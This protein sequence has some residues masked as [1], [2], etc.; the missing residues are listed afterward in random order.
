M[1]KIKDKIGGGMDKIKDKMGGKG[2]FEIKCQ[3]EKINFSSN[4]E[5]K[6]ASKVCDVKPENMK[7]KKNE[8]T[9]DENEKKRD[10]IRRRRR[11]WRIW[12]YA[13]RN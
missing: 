11:I 3:G 9:E 1:D 7:A 12:G 5:L 4:E 6:E 8:K 2:K 13:G 10:Q